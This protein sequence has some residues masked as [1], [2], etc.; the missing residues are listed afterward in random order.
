MSKWKGKDFISLNL[1][2]A[3]T[4]TNNNHNA[5]VGR[6]GPRSIKEILTFLKNSVQLLRIKPCIWSLFILLELGELNQYL[7]TN[8]Y[9]YPQSS[10]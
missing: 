5:I 7:T 9:S 10:I 3:S 8:K 1:S 6:Q 2:D 4:Y